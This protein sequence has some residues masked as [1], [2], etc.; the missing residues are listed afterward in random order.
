MN[1]SEQ[2]FKFMAEGI[3][4]DLIRLLMDRDCLTSGKAVEKVNDFNSYKVLLHPASDLYSQSSGYVYSL[5]EKE[6]KT[7]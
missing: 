5:L 1:I 4:Y 6:L 3:T 7:I 2:E